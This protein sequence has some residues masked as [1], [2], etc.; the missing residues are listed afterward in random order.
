M[1][2]RLIVFLILGFFVFGPEIQSFWSKDP[3]TWYSNY[4]AWLALV[5]ACWF[6]QRDKSRQPPE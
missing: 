4:F 6:A 2:E 3:L 1:I 5:A